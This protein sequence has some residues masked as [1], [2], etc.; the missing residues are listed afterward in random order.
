MLVFPKETVKSE[1]N[2]ILYHIIRSANIVLHIFQG[3]KLK[4]SKF[5]TKIINRTA[6]SSEK[7][8]GEKKTLNSG[9]LN[10]FN[11]VKEPWGPDRRAVFK[12][13]SDRNLVSID[14]S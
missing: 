10:T 8:S 3:I 1:V 6:S 13:R 2:T 9:S 14:M 7:R 11:I 4:Q 12:N 5:T